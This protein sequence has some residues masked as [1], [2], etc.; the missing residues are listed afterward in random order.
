MPGGFTPPEQMKGR[1]SPRNR[2]ISRGDAD[3]KEPTPP[4]AP[5]PDMGG[6]YESIAKLWAP[7]TLF[8]GPFL[9]AARPSVLPEAK[10]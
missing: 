8:R 9:S 1:G 7:G 3:K 5:A 6:M 2:G 10:P 4:A